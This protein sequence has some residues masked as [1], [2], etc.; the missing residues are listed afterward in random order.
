MSQ[1]PAYQ[2]L[3]DSSGVY[4]FI[5]DK[6]DQLWRVDRQTQQLQQI[7]QGLDDI[8]LIYSISLAA[9]A[10]QNDLLVCS[11]GSKGLLTLDSVSLQ[12]LSRFRL[13][14]ENML[15]ECFIPS[16]NS[17]LSGSG[18]GKLR[19]HSVADMLQNEEEIDNIEATASELYTLDSGIRAIK[20]V[21][22]S[23][24][25]G[26]LACGTGRGTIVVFQLKDIQAHKPYILCQYTEHKDQV[27]Q[28]EF[29]WGQNHEQYR[30]ASI[31][32]DGVLN[33]YCL[34]QRIIIYR[35]NFGW[36]SL[37][38][39]IYTLSSRNLFLLT[40][41]CALLR[42]GTEIDP[43]CG[44]KTEKLISA[45]LEM[46]IQRTF[47]MSNSGH[48]HVKRAACLRHI[49]G[50]QPDLALALNNINLNTIAVNLGKSQALQLCSE[51]FDILSG[52]DNKTLIELS[53]Q[54]NDISCCNILVKRLVEST[55]NSHL[56]LET[57]MHLMMHENQEAT[58]AFLKEMQVKE[59]E[60]NN[61]AQRLEPICGQIN[62]PFIFSESGQINPEIIR[63]AVDSD[64]RQ[65]TTSNI[66][67]DS[68]RVKVNPV[69]GSHDVQSYLETICSAP[70]DN[71]MH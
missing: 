64:P 66:V 41:R 11:C 45:N 28:I 21:Q 49:T 58:T 71:L 3:T 48:D 57:L 43:D 44:E 38:Q 8:R 27:N 5:L 24:K 7:R 14:G 13:P 42:F 36:D 31:A 23:E 29:I 60:L 54:N 16:M 47:L 40:K 62:K 20:S 10:G 63:E 59:S 69:L 18:K 33:V 19:L 30:V 51:K 6:A 55:A 34:T 9:I 12:T 2:L 70:T 52:Y 65:A 32:G 68:F 56:N 26:L 39:L 37:S 53:S 22:D 46:N 4:I 1:S 35:R 25:A 67:F 61:E 15:K 17:I 50:S